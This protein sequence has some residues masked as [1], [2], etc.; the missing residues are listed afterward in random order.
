M[1]EEFLISVIIPIYNS[2]KYLKR[3]IDSIINQTYKNIEIIC[4]NDGSTDESYNILKQYEIKD[5]RIIIL[6]KLNQGVSSARNDGIRIS[7]GQYITFVD[8]DDWLEL[9]AIENM[10]Y[11]AKNKESDA[12]RTNYY[13][14]SSDSTS[15]K[16][17]KIINR[18]YEKKEIYNN[19]IEKFIAG[20]L[21]CYTVLLL[22]KKD[23]L[24]ENN[25]FFKENI[26]MLEDKEFYINLLLNINNI[27][28]CDNMYTYH[29]YQNNS[30]TTNNVNNI[31][32]KIKSI[33]RVVTV[34]KKE[35]QDKKIYTK[36]IMEK[37]FSIHACIIINY[38]Y[39]IYKKQNMK[40]EEII[41][42]IE[43]IL[44]EKQ[45]KNILEKSTK[46]N[47]PYHFYIQ[48]ELILK[49]RYGTLLIY[50]K[51]RRMLKK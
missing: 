28:L 23:T 4:I 30:G 43:H 46:E 25:I 8:S 1:K 42:Q 41:N 26:L 12:I 22:I 3:C 27:Y 17:E 36:K 14:E 32:K 2:E 20:E 37:L 45:V 18:K 19:L 34:I 9:D 11:L 21:N 15:K 33:A 7:K 16:N 50:Y 29:Y 44:K 38:F 39:M 35:L 5:N 31:S 40:K 49:K 24:I 13:V 48:I 10:V 6:N 51:L 47:L